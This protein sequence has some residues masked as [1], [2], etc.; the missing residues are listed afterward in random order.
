MLQ[1]RQNDAEVMHKRGSDA[2]SSSASLVEQDIFAHP[3]KKSCRAQ[4]CYNSADLDSE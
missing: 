4:Q 3:R 2:D 1:S